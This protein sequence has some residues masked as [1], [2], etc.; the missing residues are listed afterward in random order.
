MFYNNLYIYYYCRSNGSSD[1]PEYSLVLMCC[2]TTDHILWEKALVFYFHI[3]YLYFVFYVTFPPILLFNINSVN[4]FLFLT[5]FPRLT[6]ILIFVRKSYINW[7]HF[8]FGINFHVFICSHIFLMNKFNENYIFYSFICVTIFERHENIVF[9]L[10]KLELKALSHRVS[11]LLFK[12][13]NIILVTVSPVPPLS[14]KPFISLLLILIWMMKKEIFTYNV[15]SYSALT[16]T[17]GT[18]NSIG[19]PIDKIEGNKSSINWIDFCSSIQLSVNEWHL[20]NKR[21]CINI[22]R[23]KIERALTPSEN[24]VSFDTWVVIENVKEY[25]VMQ[26]EAFH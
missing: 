16:T 5:C 19:K 20:N 23:S 14:L 2:P 25:K 1:Y 4:L 6:Q 18:I 17:Q 24:N 10:Y 13:I 21:L 11:P 3:K 15:S 8:K 12:S 9:F 7:T 22:F 26:I